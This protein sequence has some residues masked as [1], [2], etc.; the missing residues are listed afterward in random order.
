MGARGHMKAVEKEGRRR[1]EE[2]WTSTKWE[3]VHSGSGK[4]GGGT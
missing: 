1:L 3:H 2:F 4:G